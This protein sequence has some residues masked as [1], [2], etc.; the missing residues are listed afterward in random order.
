MFHRIGF[1]L[2]AP[3][4]VAAAFAQGAAVNQPQQAI[5]GI[6]QSF[7]GKVAVIKDA[8]GMD[9]PV[10]VPANLMINL[11]SRRK[12]S[13]IKPGDFIASGG[14][15]DKDGKIHANEIRIF[16]GPRGEGQT[17]MNQPNQV[18]TNATVTGIDTQATVKQVTDGAGAPLIKLTF[19][20]SG[21]PGSATCSGKADAAPGGAGTGCVGETQFDV[22]AN[23]PIYA[24]LPGDLSML[25]P[26]VKAMFNVT[27]NGDGNGTATRATIYEN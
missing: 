7:D 16:T 13:D 3:L 14:T 19:H 11:N 23:I 1:L 6:I 26:G 21:A 20:G 18:M 9:L 22:P 8:G 5:T 25:K 17:P 2:V 24:V 10:N 12:L 15:K 27:V 4:T